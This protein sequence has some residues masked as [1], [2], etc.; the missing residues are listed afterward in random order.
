MKKYLF[1]AT[2][3]AAAVSS[4][5]FADGNNRGT[6][7][8]T[9]TLRANNPAKC[10]LSAS[11]YTLNIGGNEISDNNGF[12]RPTVSSEV[13]DAMN[14]ANV[15]AWCTGASNKLQ[16]Y[17][18]AFVTDTGNKEADGFNRAVIYDVWM[19]IAG[20]LR[21]DL[22]DPIEG[23]SDG[24]DNGPGIGVGAGLTVGRFGPTAAAAAVTFTAD[25]TSNA[26]SNGTTGGTQA[27]SVFTGDTNR[28]I[29]G[30]Y[31]SSLTIELTPGV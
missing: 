5:A 21:S 22:Q 19:R 11:D 26:V 1:A 27:R 16:M 17:R 23:T 6:D 30:Q 13:A 25:G 28:L 2:M 3:L 9:F 15:K 18:T 12:A 10:N 31:V 29:A 4:P 20:A 14:G 7:T 24:E 8:E